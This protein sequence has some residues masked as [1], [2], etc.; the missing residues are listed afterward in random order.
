MRGKL[1]AFEGGEGSGKTTTILEVLKYFQD[2]GVKIEAFR[3]PGG[4]EASEDIRRVILGHDIEPI[5]EAMLFAASRAELMKKRI[6]P[7][8]ESGVNVLLDRGVMSS[9]CYQ[10]YC[11]DLGI[12]NVFAINKYAIGD[13]MPDL[14]V[15][16]DVDPEIGLNRVMTGDREVNRI[17]KKSLEFH[18]RVREGYLYL[19][20]HFDNIFTIINAEESLE[21]VL[22]NAINKISNVV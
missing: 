13:Y 16:L 19:S 17:D 22:K 20:Q 21:S 8:L 14:I 4:L 18:T 12:D 2:K 1:I 7:L 11:G 10:G 6:I 5:T 15:L 3:E 9:L